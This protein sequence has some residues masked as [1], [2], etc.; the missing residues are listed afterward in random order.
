[1]R[2]RHQ[3]DVE[4]VGIGGGGRA[5]GVA[6][7][8]LTIRI[9]VESESLR[10]QEMFD[11]IRSISTL[12]KI[13]NPVLASRLPPTAKGQEKRPSWF[14]NQQFLPCTLDS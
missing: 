5:G 9:R 13:M 11:E 2:V 6:A 7:G 8:G 4:D 3:V 12:W 10:G 1:M 14:K